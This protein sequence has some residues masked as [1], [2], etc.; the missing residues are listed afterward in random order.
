MNFRER[1][2]DLKFYGTNDEAYELFLAVCDLC[3]QMVDDPDKANT[4]CNWAEEMAEHS[5]IWAMDEYGSLEE[6]DSEQGRWG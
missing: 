4:L 1:I 2:E 3:Y 5:R 6:T